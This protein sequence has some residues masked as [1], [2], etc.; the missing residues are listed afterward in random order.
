VKVTHGPETYINVQRQV[1][2]VRPKISDRTIGK[3]RL[4]LQEIAGDQQV[5]VEQLSTE[6]QIEILLEAWAD[7]K[8]EFGSMWKAPW[9]DSEVG[10]GG[11]GKIVDHGR[12]IDR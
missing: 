12:L 9:D 5:P 6:S 1:E 2:S 8:K 3:L 4:A 7:E 11:P 10:D